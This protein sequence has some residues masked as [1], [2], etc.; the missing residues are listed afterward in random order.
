VATFIVWGVI[1]FVHIR[2]RN[3]LKAQG[4]AV[5]DLP[6]RAKWY[7]YGTYASLAANVFLVFFQG[8]TR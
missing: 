4:Q 3:A 6:F 5:E 8:W 1:E 2:F 7:P